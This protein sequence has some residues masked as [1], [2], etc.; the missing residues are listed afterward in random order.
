MTR[1]RVFGT[2]LASALIAGL[3]WEA[4]AV[5]A[6]APP[7]PQ[8]VWE[9][10]V[11]SRGEVALLAPKLDPGVERKSQHGQVTDGLMKLGQD[12]W[13]LITIYKIEDGAFPAFFFRR[14]KEPR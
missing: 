3:Y 5:P 9:Y 4:R 14:P 6:P 12:G 2:V 1:K 7:V 10:K 13:D 8:R 11:L